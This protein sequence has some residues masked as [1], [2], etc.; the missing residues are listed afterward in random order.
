MLFTEPLFFP[1][2]ATVLA[3]H[4]LLRGHRQRKLWLLLASYVFY[5]GWDWRFLGLILASTVLD[6]V[7]GLGM[8]RAGQ[9]PARRAWLVASLCGNLGILGFFKYFDFF[10][11]SVDPV[12]DL[13]GIESVRTLG[14]IL[15]IGIS[16][17]TF[18]TMSYTIDLYRGRMEPVR[19]FFDFALFVG[20]F[21]QLVMGPILRATGFL[22]QL[23]RPG[24]LRDVRFKALIAL[25]LIG[26]VKKA[27]VSDN[28]APWVD[29][30]YADPAAFT[31]GT[32]WLVVCLYSVQLYCDFSGYADMAIA[33]SGMLGYRVPQNFAFPFFARNVTVFWRRW[34][35]SF[36]T[37]LRDYLYFPL[38]GSRGGPRRT[39][40]N[41][42]ITMLL[43]GLWHGAGANFVVWGGLNGLGLIVHRSFTASRLP[44]AVKR[45]FHHFGV[46]L[47]FYW[48]SFTLIFFRAQTWPD[49]WEICRAFLAFQSEGVQQLSP[50]L[51]AWFAPLA[52]AHWVAWKFDLVERAERLG[53]AAYAA[54]LGIGVALALSFVRL[55]YRPFVYFQF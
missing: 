29:Q 43:S 36:S 26:F 4:W 49:A 38:G 30:V 33:L 17:Y 45:F 34:H 10:V 32:V 37:W 15:P 44:A 12:L 51:V 5:A 28:I 14:I 52:V 1:F 27:C 23:E 20:F 8:A 31:S 25:F 3:V 50:W 35:I 2:F 11:T 24:R 42:M 41:L 9:G 46:L 18:Q 40:R 54:A 13:F 6:F 55:E 48:F 19:D 16:F 47:T 53:G 21:P 39:E 22:P 7:A